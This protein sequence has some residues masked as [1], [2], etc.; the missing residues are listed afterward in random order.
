M[1][2][3]LRTLLFLLA[4]LCGYY[5]L[6]WWE[7]ASDWQGDRDLVPQ[8]GQAL[9]DQVDAVRFVSQPAQDVPAIRFE[10]VTDTGLDFTYDNGATD[11]YH[12]AE[13]LGGGI[14]ASDFDGDGM[15]D[16]VFV[17]GGDPFL[18]SQQTSNSL[19]LFKA[20]EPTKFTPIAALARCDWR[21]YGHGCCVGDFNNDGFDDFLIT[22][23]LSSVMFLNLGD[24]T[25]QDVTSPAGLVMDRWCATAAFGDLDLDGDLDLYVTAYA[26]VPTT[27]PTPYCDERGQRIHCHPHH[28]PAVPD[29]LFENL[30]DGTF[31]DRSIDSGV[32]AER[33]YG[34]GV[35][36]A[37][38]DND[39]VPEVFV[40]NDGDRNLMFRWNSGWR[41]TEVGTESGIAYS[42]DG[43]SMGSMGIACADLNGDGALDILTTNFI[44]EPNLIYINQGN[45]VFLDQSRNT[46]ISSMSRSLVGWSATAFDAN[47]DGLYDLC[48]ANGHVTPS[49]TADFEQPV[50]FFVG[51][52]TGEFYPQL[53][54]LPGKWHGRSVL[55][56]DFTRD[57]KP[58]LLFAPIYHHV[59]L[60]Q[61]TSPKT[62]HGVVLR[63]IGRTSNRSA[64]HVRIEVV[65]A[66]KQTAV[67]R[68]IGGGYLTSSTMPT[69]VMGL[70]YE[71]AG[72]ARATQIKLTWPTG[73]SN[74][75]EWNGVAR[76][77]TV[78]EP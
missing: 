24:G 76:E 20:V 33:Q 9:L 19:H 56:G 36:I 16:L 3:L 65:N 32:A 22:G 62:G 63:L 49:P 7:S 8:N 54:V 21:G 66:Q 71:Q 42:A 46:A 73:R 44:H 41:F 25:F 45:C 30:G 26:D 58:D 37:D 50:S 75:I 67:H 48:I 5:L 2:Y 72:H 59:E 40:A 47:L 74:L 17:N 38:F 11:E 68:L 14:G 60:L 57:G 34:L 61:N 23:Y 43:Q 77:I 78:L 52:K 1:P 13:T 4:A 18:S 10:N 28:Y 31:L 35:V 12:L 53:A 64:A 39:L 55:S 6:F 70:P 51:A 69:A 15:T 29:Y 27:R